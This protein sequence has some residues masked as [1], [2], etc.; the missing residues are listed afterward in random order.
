MVLLELIESAG[1]S[2]K[3]VSGTG[4][5]EYHSPCPK[6]GGT[7]RFFFQ[8][9]RQ[10][11][12]CQGMYRCRQ[13]GIYGDSIQFC[14]DILGLSWEDA[15]KRCHAEVHLQNDRSNYQQTKHARKFAEGQPPND[16]WKEKAL[17]FVNYAHKQ[18]LSNPSYMQFL[19]K[20]GISPE[21]IE[22]YKLGFTENKHSYDGAYRV[23]Y[24]DFGLPKSEKKLW[25]PAGYVIPSLEP[26][27]EVIRIKIRRSKWK[28]SDET[29]KYIALSGSM[30]GMTIVGDR[31]KENMV[32]VESELD[33]YSLIEK[34]DDV[35]FVV[36]CG[37]NTKNTDRFTDY[38][39]KDNRVF[40]CADNDEGGEA[41]KSMW[42][43]LYPKAI[44]ISTPHGKDIGEF[45]E[46]GGN[47]SSW[48]RPV[49]SY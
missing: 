9:A 28:P 32:V 16:K 40:I 41:M 46:K 24:E 29:G 38:L 36:A 45:I 14:R 10:M 25:I 23:P 48:I 12:Y 21:T 44:C 18:L 39:A 4:G 47:L 5:G 8:P 11:K 27:G 7:D 19:F 30:F 6:C 22:R 43:K 31:L 2:A 35:A 20:R 17:S 15:I 42:S 49:L 26:S 34:I 1:I 37:G 33:A 3:R 13:C